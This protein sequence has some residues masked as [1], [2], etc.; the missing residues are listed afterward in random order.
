M[1]VVMMVMMNIVVM[2]IIFHFFTLL[3]T[4]F[5]YYFILEYLYSSVNKTPCQPEKKSATLIAPMLPALADSMNGFD[6]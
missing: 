1:A 4:L 2:R 3:A 5:L 6:P